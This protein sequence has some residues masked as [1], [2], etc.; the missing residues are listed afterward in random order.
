M[1]SILSS[2]VEI[3]NANDRERERE[4]GIILMTY[5]ACPS[6]ALIV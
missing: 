3:L 4:R 6:V 1:S 5:P 2:T